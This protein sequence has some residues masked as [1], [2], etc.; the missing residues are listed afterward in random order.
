MRYMTIHGL[1]LPD[2]ALSAIDTLIGTGRYENLE[3]AIQEGLANVIKENASS[4]VREDSH[5]IY[6]LEKLRKQW[7]E[8]RNAKPDKNGTCNLE[9][10]KQMYDAIQRDQQ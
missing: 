6:G 3:Q 9:H 1:L 10:L 7:R 5:W 8:A 4:L 2:E